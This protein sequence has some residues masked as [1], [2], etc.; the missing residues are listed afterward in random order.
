MPQG[1]DWLVERLIFMISLIKTS[2]VSIQAK[3]CH[4]MYAY[5]SYKMQW[6][7]FA[8]DAHCMFNAEYMKNT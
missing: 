7:P 1:T 2:Y 6:H 3:F 8:M 5:G 4:Q